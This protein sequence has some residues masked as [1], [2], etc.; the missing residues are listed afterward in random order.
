MLYEQKN[1]LGGQL[2]LASV[3]PG[4]GEIKNLMNY[5]VGQIRKLGVKIELGKEVTPEIVENL[6]PD[7]VIVATGCK[8]VRTHFHRKKYAEESVKGIE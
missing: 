5:L 4:K 6:K 7:V 2:L 3:P 1:E 8:P